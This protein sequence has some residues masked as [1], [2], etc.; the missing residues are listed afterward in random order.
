MNA[1][2][3]KGK[4]KKAKYFVQGTEL[5][6]RCPVRDADSTHSIDQKPMLGKSFSYLDMEKDFIEVSLKNP[7]ELGD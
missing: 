5:Q 4:S 7:S 1:H 3:F 6:A 2:N